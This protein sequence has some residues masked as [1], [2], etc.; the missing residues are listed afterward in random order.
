MTDPLAHADTV[1]VLA[2]HGAP[3]RDFPASDLAE[4]FGLHMRREAAGGGTEP[5]ARESR[6]EERLRGW[7]R[8]AAN[9]PFWAASVAMGT[10]LGRAAGRRVIVGFN[11]F[12]SPSVDEALDQAAAIGLPR[13][14]VI[15][16]ML[17]RGGEHA[18]ADIPAAID[19][20][21]VRHPDI[22]IDYAW[23]YDPQDVANFLTERVR[24]VVGS[25]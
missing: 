20:A 2:V 13:I 15:T 19:R 25:P 18:E 6:L 24:L 16:P 1:I 22:I 23:P 4:Y 12:C 11:E 8:T 21:R 9:D 14:V 7:P 3:P 17:T 10:T 5:N